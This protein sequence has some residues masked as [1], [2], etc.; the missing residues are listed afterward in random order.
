MPTQHYAHWVSYLTQK[1]AQP[2]IAGLNLSLAKQKLSHL[3][4][5]ACRISLYANSENVRPDGI[6]NPE[7]LEQLQAIEDK[8]V[9]LAERTKGALFC[10][11]LTGNGKRE[12]I[13]Y[14]GKPKQFAKKMNAVLK[15][16]STIKTDLTTE[17][18]EKWTVYFD[19]LYPSPKE[20]NEIENRDI[21]L[22]LEEQG[23]DLN[24]PRKVEHAVY[25]NTEE[26]LEQYQ[27]KVIQQ[28]FEIEK[29]DLLEDRKLAPFVLK[30]THSTSLE[31]EVINGRTWKLKELAKASSGVYDGW[32]V[33]RSTVL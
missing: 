4:P 1:E 25:F 19:A 27:D 8:I 30:F 26:D 11:W 12:L 24:S 13:F 22:E 28:G 18:D 20:M 2:C 33:M 3:Y 29:R 14:I 5:F 7:E 10:G 6:P 21:L 16:K 9:A 17:K 23:D 32:D 31:A 15:R